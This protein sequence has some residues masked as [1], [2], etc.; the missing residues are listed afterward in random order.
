MTDRRHPWLIAVL[1][2][3]VIITGWWAWS[4]HQRELPP[5]LVG[6]PRSDYQ[7]EQFELLV[8]DE[9]GKESFSMRGPRL[10]RH[11]SLGTLDIEDPR[12][13][14]P[15]G[16]GKVWT[17]R[18][19]RAWVSRDGD[20]L[21]LLEKVELRGPTTAERV[22]IRLRSEQLDFLPK[23]DQIESDDWVTI[24]A[25]GSILR[26]K[27]LKAELASRRIELLSEVTARYEPIAR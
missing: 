22:P 2:L 13:R 8:F 27:G 6:P 19:E 12:M 5:P 3:A 10:A 26:G 17:G 23:A 9:Q 24:T 18:A 15:D 14:A 4:L 1:S 16:E 7:I 20:R 25:P 11:P 21:R